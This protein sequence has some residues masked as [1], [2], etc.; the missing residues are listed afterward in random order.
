MKSKEV[1][2]IVYNF[3][4]SLTFGKR[5]E[6][7]VIKYLLDNNEDV[8]DVSNNKKYQKCDI[9]AF[10][11]TKDSRRF[12]VEIKTDSFYTGN[13]FFEFISSIDP[14]SLGC[15]IKTK[16]D[17]LFYFF[18]KTKE[19][20]ILNMKKY[21]AFVAENMDNFQWKKVKNTE[22]ESVGFLVPKKYLEEN[23]KSYKKV[24]LNE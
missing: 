11:T 6:D 18:I 20:Y 19:L 4:D 17:F 2:D 7:I 5:G 8:C 9:D 10:V 13:I 14:F 24:I 23:F 3:H 12:S 15:M 22:Y 16:A 21:R 1:I